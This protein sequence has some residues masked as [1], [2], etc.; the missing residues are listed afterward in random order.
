[1]NFLG[2]KTIFSNWLLSEYYNASVY[3]DISRILENQNGRRV[4][5]LTVLKI[6]LFS[7][8]G[9]ASIFSLKWDCSR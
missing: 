1:M 8:I 5:V 6:K 9:K 3:Q 2:T 7:E 4:P